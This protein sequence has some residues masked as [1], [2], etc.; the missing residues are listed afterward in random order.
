MNIKELTKEEFEKLTVYPGKYL[1]I[2]S[3]TEGKASYE[4]Q[5]YLFTY[6]PN[7]GEMLAGKETVIAHMVKYYDI[8]ETGSPVDSADWKVSDGHTV[9]IKDQ[10]RFTSQTF[11]VGTK[12]I[13]VRPAVEMGDWIDPGT[14]AVRY[15]DVRYPSI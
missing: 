15:P 9:L 10:N 3:V 2:S 7:V 8:S 12:Y 4:G 11:P 6:S 13:V 1:H 5:T 14:L